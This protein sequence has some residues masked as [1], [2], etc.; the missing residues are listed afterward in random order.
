MKFVTFGRRHTEVYEVKNSFQ[1]NVA[2]KLK[3]NYAVSGHYEWDKVRPSIEIAA[4][5]V[6]ALEVSVNFFVGNTVSPLN[7]CIMKR[8]QDFQLLA[9]EYNTQLFVPLDVFLSDAN[10]KKAY[11]Q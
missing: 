8:I 11:G 2:N 3:L 1:D 7:K 10:T 9:G 4:A 6:D 5:I